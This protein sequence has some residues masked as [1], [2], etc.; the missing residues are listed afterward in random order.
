VTSP[1]YPVTAIDPQVRLR[2]NKR[3]MKTNL[4]LQVLLPNLVGIACESLSRAVTQS[5]QSTFPSQLSLQ[6]TAAIL[7]TAVLDYS[8][9]GAGG[10]ISGVLVG[11]VRAVSLSAFSGVVRRYPTC[12][13]YRDCDV[14]AVTA[15]QC[16]RFT[17]F[18]RRLLRSEGPG[19]PY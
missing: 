11:A 12:P 8:K 6:K 1:G 17:L 9:P 3:K 15:L 19:N 14:R 5:T 13:V 7:T 16:R 4:L 10:G 18:Y 2:L